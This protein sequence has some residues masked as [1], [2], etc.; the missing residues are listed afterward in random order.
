MNVQD[1]AECSE[2][3]NL[4]AQFSKIKY[5]HDLSVSLHIQDAILKIFSDHINFD[6]LKA[7]SGEVIPAMNFKK[8]L[9][10]N[11]SNVDVFCTHQC[12]RR[13]LKFLPTIDN[14]SEV[15]NFNELDLI[16]L[17][18]Q[19]PVLI[20]IYGTSGSGKSTLSKR[21]ATRY[22]ISNVLSTDTVRKKMREKVNKSENPLLHASTF[23]TGDFL[24]Q[25]DYDRIYA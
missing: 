23:E 14:F 5:T 8:I 7:N 13:V 4:V 10:R 16:T 9:I 25:A 15:N 17:M 20:L 22:G 12:M 6:S 19:K 1:I 18:K 2:I 21:L 24:S 3:S 11:G